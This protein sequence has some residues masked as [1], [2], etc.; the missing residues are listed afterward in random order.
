MNRN[1][2][3]YEIEW[4]YRGNARGDLDLP[5]FKMRPDILNN[6]LVEK[7]NQEEPAIPIVG[8]IDESTLKRFGESL[9]FIEMLK[10]AKN[11]A[12]PATHIEICSPGGIV[13]PGFAIMQKIRMHPGATIGQVDGYAYSCGAI[14]LQGCQIR[15]MGEYSEMMIHTASALHSVT[16]VSLRGAKLKKLRDYIDRLHE[17]IVSIFVKR[18]M[19]T[20]SNTKSEAEVE[21]YIR[22]LMKD[23]K[24]LSADEAVYYKLADRVI[25]ILPSLNRVKELNDQVAN[26]KKQ[27]LAHM[28]RS[29][30]AQFVEAPTG[31]GPEVPSPEMPL[32]QAIGNAMRI[33]PVT[34][35]L[36]SL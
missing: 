7:L 12:L 19:L 26:M 34:A 31:L 8:G 13:I 11:G 9:D 6:I 5:E 36:W 24:F 21:K 14:I 18:I 32:D 2:Q 16:N 28:L 35:A 23:E 29:A 33:N 10:K 17:Q 25:D 22:K 4:R 30:G 3:E 1:E 15:L 20:R 27:Q